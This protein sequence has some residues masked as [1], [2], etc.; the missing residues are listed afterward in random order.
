[1]PGED[2][3]TTAKAMLQSTQKLADTLAE[4]RRASPPPK[5]NLK[6]DIELPNTTGVIDPRI[7]QMGQHPE[8]L[9]TNV[10]LRNNLIS[11]R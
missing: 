9:K 6:K 7:E 4:S 3:L 1:M 11:R 8:D 10:Q 5:A 2:P